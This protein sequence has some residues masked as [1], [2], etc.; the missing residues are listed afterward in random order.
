[1]G[2]S[3]N[4]NGKGRQD[5]KAQEK[6]PHPHQKKSI[7]GV[8]CREFVQLV[9]EGNGI[10]LSCTNV[11]FMHVSLG[12]RGSKEGWD[13]VAG[14]M[15]IGTSRASFLFQHRSHSSG[16]KVWRSPCGGQK[17]ETFE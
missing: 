16:V 3:E 11:P 1:M 9:G 15:E 6:Q 4:V 13:G 7:L 12:K 14:R 5:A 2:V 10:T 8:P 17:V